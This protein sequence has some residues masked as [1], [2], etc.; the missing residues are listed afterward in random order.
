MVNIFTLLPRL[1]L[2]VCAIFC[3]C[4]L[5][6]LSAQE[7]VNKSFIVQLEKGKTMSGHERFAS[8]PG[9]SYRTRQLCD[10]PMNLWLIESEDA[11]VELRSIYKG[12]RPEDQVTLIMDNKA[13]SLRNTP[14][15]SLYGKQWQYNNDGVNS[16]GGVPGADINAE[17]AWDIATGGLTPAGD[18]IVVA[19]VD[20]GLDIEHVDIAPNL[21]TNRFEIPN[22]SIDNDG[23]GYIDDIHGWNSGKDN[24]DISSGGSH[25][26]P[27]TGIIGAKGNN[28]I[29]V[30][31][32]NWNVQ[33]MTISYGSA[34]EA[35]ALAAYAYAYKMRKRYN[36]TNGLE[37]AFV[38][39]TNSS[40]G[41]DRGKADEAPL[42]CAMYDSLGS[43][44]ILSMG[45]TANA[46]LNIDVEGDLPTSCSSE[47]LISVTNLDKND[48]KVTGAGF[49]AR[50]IDIGAYGSGTYTAAVNNKYASFGGTSG[51][52]PHVTGAVALLYS[53]PCADLA[54]LYK[55]DPARA[56]LLVKD[57]ILNNTTPNVSI[58][59]ITT[60]GGKLNL[61]K[62]AA[63]MLARCGV[64]EAPAAIATALTN[65]NQARIS[66]ISEGGAINLRYK[67]TSDFEWQMVPGIS[68][69][70]VVLAGLDYCTPYLFQLRYECNGDTSDW[71]ST[72][73]FDTEGCCKAPKDIAIEEMNGNIQIISPEGIETLIE[74]R[75]PGLDWD[76][77]FFMGTLVLDELDSC[78]RY[79]VRYSA[80]CDIAGRYSDPSPIG[81]LSSSCGNCTRNNYCSPPPLENDSEWIESIT[82]NGQSFTSGQDSKGYGRNLGAFIPLF[83]QS[84]SLF[85]TLTPGFSGSAY[86]EFFTAFV[87]WNQD[88]VLEETELIAKSPK[89]DKAALL[90]TVYVPADAIAGYTR[91]R[92]VMTYR[93]VSEAC[94]SPAEYGEVEDY[95]VLVE[96]SLSSNDDEVLGSITL[97][98]NPTNGNFQLSG[99]AETSF[100]ELRIYNTL[101][102]EVDRIDLPLKNDQVTVQSNL[103]AGVYHVVLSGS[104]GKHKSRLV[105]MQ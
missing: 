17:A 25:G 39:A 92:V 90:D 70:S 87:D 96:K 33:L 30:T 46:N 35:N 79:E 95:C 23:N 51:A 16:G 99:L 67:K 36:D 14:D 85:I 9:G 71:S 21:W 76:S 40:W 69:D 49:G 65:F 89:A 83:R 63:A 47:Y 82:L 61:G 5:A 2:L 72:R 4:S 60:S 50:T 13:L 28:H 1:N 75:L 58:S 15:D 57:I 86:S 44:G 43:V 98:P 20:D 97:Y 100:D 59:T 3:L 42:W 10:L 73:Y 12:L 103:P 24:N 48:T 11:N 27:V 18:T 101:G 88:G 54:T 41:I 94:Q 8:L 68:E 7:K 55:A 29:G 31:G 22:D 84:D 102:I 45:A 104:K 77:I 6:N 62:S 74:Y 53:V 93:E 32:V 19:I 81:F 66:W 56:A 37:G 38:V 91:M 64:C 105:V 34:N 52:T 26:T 78:Q 80:Y